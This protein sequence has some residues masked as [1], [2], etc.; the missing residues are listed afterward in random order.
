MATEVVHDAQ[1]SA[2]YLVLDGDRVGRTDYEIRGDVI[3]FT[4]TEIDPEHREGGLGGALVEGALEHV[5][6][7][8]D[9]RLVATCPFTAAWLDEH[10]EYQDLLSR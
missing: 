3:D 6:T 9:F 8:T 5:R 7:A 4:H 2:Y 10:P 1:A